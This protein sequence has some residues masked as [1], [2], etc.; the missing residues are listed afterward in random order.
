MTP[1]P[2]T[3][4]TPVKTMTRGEAKAFWLETPKEELI[5]ALDGLRAELLAEEKKKKEE[6]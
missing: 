2:D 5:A 3:P 1:K 6:K 4:A